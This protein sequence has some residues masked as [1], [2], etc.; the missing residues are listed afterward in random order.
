LHCTPVV[1]SQKRKGKKNA[2]KRGRKRRAGEKN[3]DLVALG[4]VHHGGIINLR[5]HGAAVGRDERKSDQEQQDAHGLGQRQNNAFEQ[6]TLERPAT[7]AQLRKKDKH[8]KKKEPQLVAVST[9]QLD[10]FSQGR[11]VPGHSRFLN[12]LPFFAV[13]RQ[14]NKIEQVG[15]DHAKGTAAVQR[16]GNERGGPVLGAYVS[17]FPSYSWRSIW[18]AG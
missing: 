14:S 9:S 6:A 4:D 18:G 15:R 3:P 10:A 11:D 7:G 2:R 13:A 17:F 16:L 8:R 1:S 12:W 5:E